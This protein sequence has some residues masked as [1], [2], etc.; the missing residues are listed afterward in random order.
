LCKYATN[1]KKKKVNFREVGVGN[2]E[3]RQGS[4]LM[5]EDELALEENPGDFWK[6]WGRQ[7]SDDAKMSHQLHIIYFPS[8]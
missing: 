6:L 1:R 4:F 5:L 2:W 8:S 7:Q 3:S